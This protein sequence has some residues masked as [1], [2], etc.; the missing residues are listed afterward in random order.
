M[1]DTSARHL[2]VL[3]EP[4]SCARVQCGA[5]CLLVGL[6]EILHLH[7]VFAYEGTIYACRDG[8]SLCTGAGNTEPWP[9]PARRS[10]LWD[11]SVKR[12]LAAL[13]WVGLQI[14]LKPLICYMPGTSCLTLRPEF[15]VFA[16]NRVIRPVA[17]VPWVGFLVTM[18]RK[19]RWT[20]SI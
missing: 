9:G 13:P 4:E 8:C 20:R 17:A 11:R 7:G 14:K 6:V 15:A 12:P 3:A 5:R 16:G 1:P 18:P 19:T 10:L 2:S